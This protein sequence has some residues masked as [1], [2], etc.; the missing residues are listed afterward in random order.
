[1]NIRCFVIIVSCFLVA[2]QGVFAQISGVVSTAAGQ[3]IADVEV[4]VETTGEGTVTDEAGRF[5]VKAKEGEIITFRHINYRQFYLELKDPNSYL[6]IVLQTKSQ[7]LSPVRVTASRGVGYH[8]VNSKKIEGLPVLLGENDVV[9]YLATLPGVLTQGLLHSGFHVRGGKSSQNGFFIH[10]I[11]VAPPRHLSG[12]LT[13]YDP[14]VFSSAKMHKGFFPAAFNGYLSS[15]VNMGMKDDAFNEKLSG[16]IHAGLVSSSLKTRFSLGE[17]KSAKV[18]LSVRKSYYD[19]WNRY[20]EE[21]SAE[22]PMP[23][24]SFGD[25]SFGTLIRLNNRWEL[26]CMAF[27][28]TDEL[29]L[30]KGDYIGYAMEWG[31]YNGMMTL[32]GSFEDSSELLVSVGTTDYHASIETEGRVSLKNVHQER[33]VQ[34]KILYKKKLSGSLYLT[35]TAGVQKRDFNYDQWK[36]TKVGNAAF[37]FNLFQLSA[38]MKYYFDNGVS[39]TGG[40]NG[41]VFQREHIQY[42]LA[43]RIGISKSR[44]QSSV[45]L[46]YSRTHQFHER[47]Q[48]L[49]LESPVDYSIPVND[50]DQPAVSDQFSVGVSHS[51]VRNYSFSIE[52]YYRDLDNCKEMMPNDRTSM[53]WLY[54]DMM[55]GSG[56]AYGVEAQGKLLFDRWLLRGNY[57]YS[58]TKLSF[59]G[60]SGGKPFSPGYDMPHRVL[61]SLHYRLSPRF[62]IKAAW[63]YRSGAVTT[64]PNGISISQNFMGYKNPIEIVPLYNQKYNYRLPASHHLDV[65]VDYYADLFSKELV[66]SVGVYNLYNRKNADFVYLEPYQNT[67]YYT[68]FKIVKR[69]LLPLLPYA[70]V[71]FKF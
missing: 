64:L 23:A 7:Q 66:L 48:V 59:A 63:T 12:I 16:E 36:E 15:F 50:N 4:F 69:A 1:M 24:Y 17:K 6:N 22:S 51:G 56:Y 52:A 61:V 71:S 29:P 35:T 40:V 47:M 21:V 57:T 8:R 65:N 33:S 25:V 46:N 67:A 13:T 5:V 70:K 11:E 28:T 20:K 68:R 45:W 26:S 49:T 42:A 32:K 38:E 31:T 53:Q 19:F 27:A 14:W 3:P 30:D 41:I 37:N 2:T 44:G 43:P 54:A 34:S 10:Q 58:R 55:D 9:K 62:R 60:I 18:S 39:L